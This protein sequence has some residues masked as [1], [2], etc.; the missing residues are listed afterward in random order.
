[1]VVIVLRCAPMPVRQRVL[2][3]VAVVAAVGAV[4]Y[5][6]GLMT[7]FINGYKEGMS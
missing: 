2:A 6:T 5:H 4:L 3:G 7:E 1:M